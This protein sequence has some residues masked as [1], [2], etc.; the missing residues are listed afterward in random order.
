MNIL[1]FVKQV[2]D[3]ETRIQLQ[4]GAVDTSSVKWV[5]NPYDEFA[6]EEALRIK[7]KLGQGKVTV[8]SLGPDRVKEA[9][10]YALSLG[11]DEG[12][13]VKGDGL[14]LADPL[15][16]ATVLAAA[17]KKAGFDLILTGKQGVDHDWSQAGI[18]LAELLDLPHVSVVVHLEV[19][20]ASKQGKAK[21]EVEGGD[22]LVEFSLP[23]VITA[24]KGL[25]EPRYASLKGIMAVKKKV[26]P[27]W[28]LAD[29]GVDP[30]S[31]SESAASI[32]FVEFSLPPP[33]QAGKILEGDP[34]DTVPELVRIL[35]REAKVL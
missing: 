6:I 33:R 14:A 23:A 32:R 13:H 26:I 21:R 5:A 31:V 7:E 15:A 4:N 12:V 22:E 35:H 3:T 30:A 17:A 27:E 8:V 28:T 2:P 24:Q 18:I 10:K 9:I 20:A 19:D 11:A 34:K 29:L 16:V 1:V 25:N